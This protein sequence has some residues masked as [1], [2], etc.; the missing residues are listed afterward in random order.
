MS[1]DALYAEM[2][3]QDASAMYGYAGASATA[4]QVSPFTS[5]PQTT[6]P[7]GPAGQVAA[8]AQSVGTSGGT[9]LETLMSSG[10]QLISSTPQ[11]LQSLSSPQALSGLASTAT[12]TSSSLSSTSL[13]N[14]L[15]TPL[16]M[17]TMPMSMLSRLFT[18]G[19]TANAA[20]AV[21]TAAN[22]LGAVQSAGVGSGA[23]ALASTGFGSGAPAVAAGLGQA[24][25]VGPLSVPSSWAGVAPSPSAAAMP[26]ASVVPTGHAGA[27][28]MP[29]MMPLTNVAGRSASAAPSR[30]ELRS[31]V[32]PF[33]PAGG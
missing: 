2:W 5:P 3:A 12:D 24:T 32:I 22:E 29:P 31:T 6:N 14:E 18:T 30:F 4:S 17:A 9:D 25:S 7:S 8:T 13:L 10:P 27:T 26:P 23:K 1:T 28:A 16:R 19:S 15:S 21:S 33:S 20:R 11:A